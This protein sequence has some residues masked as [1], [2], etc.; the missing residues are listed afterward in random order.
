MMDTAGEVRMNS[1]AISTYG[2]LQMVAIVVR[3]ASN[4]VHIFCVDTGFSLKDLLWA[5]GDR[6]EWREREREREWEREHS[7]LSVQLDDGLSQGVNDK[8]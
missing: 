8:I 7:V 3:P 2:L 4:C 1:E 5:M 6:E